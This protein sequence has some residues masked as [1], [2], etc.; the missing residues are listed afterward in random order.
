MIRSTILFTAIFLTA[1]ASIADVDILC[2]AS[3][4]KCVEKTTFGLLTMKC[5]LDSLHCESA[6]IEGEDYVICSA[7]SEN[8]TEPTSELFGFTSA[9]TKCHGSTK[10]SLKAVDRDLSLTWTMGLISDYVRHICVGE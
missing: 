3:I 5:R 10:T 4:E 8:C 7:V 2:N 1:T 6:D 9:A